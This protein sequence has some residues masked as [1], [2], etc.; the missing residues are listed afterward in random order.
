M[1]VTSDMTMIVTA[2]LSD[3]LHRASCMARRTNRT[4]GNCD[5][6][7]SILGG[8]W[9]AFWD[10]LRLL[11]ALLT[12]THSHSAAWT[13]SRMESRTCCGRL[14]QTCA[15]D[16]IC[17]LSST[18]HSQCPAA[19]SGDKACSDLTLECSAPAA[20][21]SLPFSQLEETLSVASKSL[22]GSIPAAST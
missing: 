18:A 6:R 19:S 14:G 13:S 20:P 3:Y 21:A 10:S 12:T 11:N 7:L 16:S 17:P 1:W 9:N 8:E 5:P 4:F 22:A 2:L 15:T